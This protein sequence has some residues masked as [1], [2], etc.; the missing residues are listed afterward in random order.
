MVDGET[1]KANSP[2]F[3][4]SRFYFVTCIL[5]LNTQISRGQVSDVYFDTGLSV[6]YFN[7][8][9]LQQI[10]PMNFGPLLR[11]GL[12]FYK[13]PNEQFSFYSEARLNFRRIRRTFN[14]D[15]FL[16]RIYASEFP[17]YAA[18]NASDKWQL[19]MGV[20]PMLYS[21]SLLG[22]PDNTAVAYTG[23]G[24][25]SFDVST[26]IG[27]KYRLSDQFSL[28]LRSELGLIPMVK[29]FPI[30]D[31]GEIGSAQTD[32]LYRRVEIFVRWH[33]K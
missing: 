26:L 6:H 21:V 13:T 17:L 20:N 11:F 22:D 18:W 12:S 24:F 16:Y 23:R 2:A 4:V 31:F 10:D 25:R 29:Y 7:A 30:G 1:K 15:E 8:S 5:L 28:G 32:V 3:R 19:H 9:H 27:L 14:D 33:L